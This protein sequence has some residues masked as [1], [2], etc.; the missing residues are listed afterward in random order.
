M[1]TPTILKLLI[2]GHSYLYEKVSVMGNC[3]ADFVH[4]V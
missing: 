4:N 2:G 1:H 3:M